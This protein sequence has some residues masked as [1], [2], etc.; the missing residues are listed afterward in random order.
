M[1]RGKVIISGYIPAILPSFTFEEIQE[2]TKFG[3]ER[4][5]GPFYAFSGDMNEDGK[6]KLSVRVNQNPHLKWYE[7]YLEA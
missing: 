3:D 6:G 2:K 7:K 1:R 4:I 5:L